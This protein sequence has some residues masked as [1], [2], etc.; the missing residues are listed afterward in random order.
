MA[1]V[2]WRRGPGI[3]QVWMFLSCY[4]LPGFPRNQGLSK[5]L[6]ASFPLGIII[7]GAS[8][9]GRACHRQ[10]ERQCPGCPGSGGLIPGGGSKSWVKGVWEHCS[11]RKKGAA[12]VH[13][14]LHKPVGPHLPRRLCTSKHLA[15]PHHVPHLCV[16]AMSAPAGSW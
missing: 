9:K 11:R 12:A 13:W 16:S 4:V 15:G 1:T 3:S 10:M 7:Q 6:S 14:L 2:R 8:V 5:G